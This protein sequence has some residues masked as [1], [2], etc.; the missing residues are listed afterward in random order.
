MITYFAKIFKIS[1]YSTCL[2]SYL[3]TKDLVFLYTLNSIVMYSSFTDYALIEI[4]LNK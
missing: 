2:V 1:E 4:T 3:V